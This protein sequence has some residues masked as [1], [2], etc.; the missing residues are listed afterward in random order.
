MVL[1][2]NEVLLRDERQTLSLMA[3]SGELTCLTGGTAQQRSRWLYT[4]MG[5]DVILHGFVCIDGEPLTEYSAVSFRR[6]MA[7][8]PARLETCGE[9][10]KYAPPS[11]QDVFNLQANREQPISNGILGEEVRRI[12][13]EGNESQVQLM[14]VA[15]L[16]GKPV[17]LVDNPPEQSFA[18]LSSQARKG[19][20]VVVTSDCPVFINGADMVVEL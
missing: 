7:F 11:V 6:L 15:V 10:N 13:V 2:L 16:L 20:L 3:K 17:L 5:L 19:K 8:S 9:V 1:E 18:Y 12:G 4:I 14:A